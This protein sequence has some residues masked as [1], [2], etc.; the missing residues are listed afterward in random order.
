MRLHQI[1]FLSFFFIILFLVKN[2]KYKLIQ[3]KLQT[4]MMQQIKLSEMVTEVFFSC[5]LH[6]DC[7]EIQCK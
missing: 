1:Y 2:K 3:L 7:F 6:H 4:S 5:K